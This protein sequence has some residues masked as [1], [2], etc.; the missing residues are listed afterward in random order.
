M[1]TKIRLIRIGIVKKPFYR[2]IITDS[3]SPRN[4]RIIENLGIYNPMLS[5][6]NIKRVNLKKDRVRYWL[7]VGAIPTDRIKVLL[8]YKIS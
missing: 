5:K 8:N 2:I 1:V 4:S 6:N 3:R 7:S